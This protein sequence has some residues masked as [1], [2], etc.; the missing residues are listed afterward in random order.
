MEMNRHALN[1]AEIPVADF[2]RAR[3]FYGTIFDFEMPQM[4]AGGNT[5]GFLLFEQGQ[6]V[7]AAIVHGEG[8]VPSAQGSLVYLSAGRDLAVV[9]GRV[10]RAGGVVLRGKTE[11]GPKLGHYALFRDTEGNR[12]GLHSPE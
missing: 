3:R 2:E 9:L 7:G 5:L 4:T 10:V 6:G 12:V 1:W 11:I 8:H